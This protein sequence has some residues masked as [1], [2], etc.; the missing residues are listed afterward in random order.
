MNLKKNALFLALSCSLPAL[1]CPDAAYSQNSPNRDQLI[2]E[3]EETV[4]RYTDAAARHQSQMYEILKSEYDQRKKGIEKRYGKR[5]EEGEEEE[6]VRRLEAIAMLEKFIQN[7]PNREKYT[8]DAMFRLADLYLDQS[9]YEFALAFDQQELFAN[10][11]EVFDEAPR[12]DYSKSLKLWEDITAKFPKYRQ[13]NGVLYLLSYYLNQIGETRKSLQIARGL[14]C[15]QRY[16]PMDTPAQAPTRREAQASVGQTYVDVYGSC[17]EVDK[18]DDL[19][20]ST[21]SRIIGDI[22]FTTPGELQ[23]AISAYNKAVNDPESKY[24]DEALYRLAWSYYRN[25]DFIKGID[26][27]D[28]S[29][30]RFDKEKAEGNDP[31]DLRDE[32][33]QYIAISFTDPWTTQEQPD[34]VKGWERATDFYKDRMDEPHVRDVFVKLGDTFSLLEAYTQAGDA[35]RMALKQWPLHPKNPAVH[36]KIVSAYESLG[37]SDLANDEATK[38]TKSYSEDTEWFTANETNR[39]AMEERQQIGERM[40]RAAAENS[41]KEAQTLRQEYLEAPSEGGKSEYVAQYIQAAGL[42][43]RFLKEHPTSTLAYEFTYRLG[44]TLYWGEQYQD[45]VVHYRWVRDHRELSEQRFEKAAHSVVKSYQQEL[46]LAIDKS[47]VK[48][49]PLPTVEDLK[50]MPKPVAAMSIPVA[51]ANLQQALDEY[52]TLV[53]DPKTAPEMGYQAALVSYRHLDLP[54][55]E[56]RFKV[57]LDKFCGAGEAVKAKDALL[58]IYEATGDDDKFHETNEKFIA[59]KCGSTDDIELAVAQNRS[60]EFREAAE[61]FARE[62]YSLAARE[63]YKYYKTTPDGDPNRPVSLYNA[64]ISYE[65]S[66]KP[67]TA[68]YLFKE[69]TENPATEFRDSEYFLPALYLTAVSH[70]KAFDYK[71][72]VTTYLNVVKAAD[73]DRKPPAGDRTLEQIKLDALFNAALLRE[74]DR[75]YK[76]PRSEKGTGAASLYKRYAAVE[77]ERRKSDR[78]YWAIARLWRESGDIR[79]LSN[80]YS[81]WRSK[82]GQDPG[83]ADDFVY[84]YYDLAKLS[85]K[86]GR[87]SDTDKYRRETIRAWETVGRPK[88]TAAS[89]MAAEFAFAQAEDFYDK[90]FT[91]FSIK[92]TPKTKAEADR[93][94]GKLDSTA[95]SSRQKY[96][97]IA[98]FESGPFGLAALVRIGDIRFFQGIKITEIP[99]PKEILKLDEQKPELGVLFQYQDAITALVKPL[100]EGAKQQWEKVVN[101]GKA[102]GVANQWTQTAQERLHD[103]V[104][105]AE[106]PTLRPALREG[107]DIP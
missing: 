10:D 17:G 91:P 30:V 63:F 79:L 4:K 96:L 78:A 27:F 86:K 16:N 46:Q 6:R 28:R 85:A 14:V 29:I 95:E 25:D 53:D 62:E 13:R 7:Y 11:D 98:K 70:Y 90:K 34:P 58:A 8:P 41:H 57:T 39:Q 23:L 20:L 51:Y 67:K 103:F 87:K 37:D 92:S 50:V 15:P 101:I 36:Q 43:E 2:A 40:L 84:S 18:S 56:K 26:A 1:T 81:D 19:R 75:V 106:Y 21:W 24:H 72:A 104:S 12:A 100:E 93:V 59:S 61:I 105:Q 99:I 97:D 5:I 102:Q 69:F 82:Y 35:Y 3:R 73:E 48:E 47:Q 94:L 55:A 88:K 31:I 9:D 77:P 71:S 38:L 74:L 44:E 65:R 83:N 64:A 33:L 89:D 107:T 22:H 68:V 42:Y 45:A 32:A 80:A 54:D 66:G 60:K 76:D 52:Q 49:P